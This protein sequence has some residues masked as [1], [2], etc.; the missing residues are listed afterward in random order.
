MK[1]QKTLDHYVSKKIDLSSEQI[2]WLIDLLGKGCRQD[3]KDRLERRLSLTSLMPNYG[4]YQRVF[5]NKQTVE[6]CA[7]QSYPDEIRFIRQ[8]ILKG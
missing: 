6:Y 2:Y 4:I 8:L 5:I 1:K 3:T 7:G